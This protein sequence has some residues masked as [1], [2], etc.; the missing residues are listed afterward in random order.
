[1]YLYVSYMNQ[2]VHP[3]KQSILVFGQPQTAC[4]VEPCM[5]SRHGWTKQNKNAQKAFLVIGSR[6]P[7]C[8]VEFDNCANENC[9]YL[10][11]Y[12][13]VNI[14][15]LLVSFLTKYRLIKTNTGYM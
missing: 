15:T 1:M 5:V 12:E 8:R 11:K 9:S 6:T 10:K 7:A 4:E 13:K 14:Y 3:D 2:L